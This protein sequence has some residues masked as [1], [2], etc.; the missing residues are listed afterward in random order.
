MDYDMDKL[1]GLRFQVGFFGSPCRACFMKNTYI[2]YLLGAK[3]EFITLLNH[4]SRP[5]RAE[6]RYILKSD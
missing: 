5:K 2:S 3:F 4:V 6:N 1:K